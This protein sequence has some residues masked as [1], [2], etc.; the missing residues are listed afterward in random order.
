MGFIRG[1][2]LKLIGVKETIPAPDQRQR[3]VT[4][5]SCGWRCPTYPWLDLFS[6]VQCPKCGGTCHDGLSRMEWAEQ[7]PEAD[8]G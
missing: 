2:I 4:C 8:N 6:V 7:N 5:Y 3:W 1:V